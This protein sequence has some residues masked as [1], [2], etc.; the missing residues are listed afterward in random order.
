MGKA[1]NW[2]SDECR[3]VAIA[4]I[5]ASNDPVKGS[6][7]KSSVF[8]AAVMTNLHR[9]APVG[10]H[11]GRYDER[12][13]EAVHSFWRDTLFRD[14]SK[15]NKALRIVIASNPTGCTEQE[16]INMAVAIHLKKTKRMDYH[17]KSFNPNQW[18]FYQ[19]WEELRRIPKF[20]PPSWTGS[21]MAHADEEMGDDQPP[22]SENDTQG[23]GDNT[24]DHEKENAPSL[25]SASI[26]TASRRGGGPGQ[27][28]AKAA[29]QKHHRDEAKLRELKKLNKL[30]KS[31]LQLQTRSA[32]ILELRAT[33]Q[34]FDGIDQEKCNEARGALLDLMRHPLSSIDINTSSSDDNDE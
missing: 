28:A 4:W 9:L 26:K 18:R 23:H 20:A 15:F 29:A 34:A 14:V 19:A 7:Q 1:R 3:A 2:S 24:T 32:R 5:N 16:K 27:K 22:E 21:I 6:D 25:A 12:G 11:E 30:S 8:V 31:R 33:L 13:S 10:H 17:Y